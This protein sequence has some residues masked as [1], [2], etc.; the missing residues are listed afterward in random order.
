[1]PLNSYTAPWNV[2]NVLKIF[3]VLN[4]LDICLEHL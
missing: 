3:P 1:L 4:L 2:K